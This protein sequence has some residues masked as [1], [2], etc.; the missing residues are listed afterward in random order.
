M[1]TELVLPLKLRDAEH[2]HKVGTVR[3]QQWVYQAMNTYVHVATT[4]RK[5]LQLVL[6]IRVLKEHTTMNWEKSDRMTV[7]IVLLENTAQQVVQLVGHVPKVTT[8][9]R[10][11]LLQLTV[12]QELSLKKMVLKLRTSASHVLLVNTAQLV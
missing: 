12:Q 2:V 3:S 1:A 5:E 11:H 6:S 7:L 8:V 9:Q 4:V 10:R